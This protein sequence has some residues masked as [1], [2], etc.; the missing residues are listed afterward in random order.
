MVVAKVAYVRASTE[1]QNEARQRD[2]LEKY[3]IS[4]WLAEKA[5][6]NTERNRECFMNKH[7]AGQIRPTLCLFF[8]TTAS[9]VFYCTMMVGSS[10]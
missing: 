5:S 8:E 6:G 2:A 9:T 7:S 3:V 10:T 4:K 1:E